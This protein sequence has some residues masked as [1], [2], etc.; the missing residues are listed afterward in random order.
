MKSD[1]CRLWQYATPKILLMRLCNERNKE[2][3]RGSDGREKRDKWKE[4]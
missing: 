1:N 2:G 3:R 4:E